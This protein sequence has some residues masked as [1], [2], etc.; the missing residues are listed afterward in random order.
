MKRVA[1]AVAHAAAAAALCVLA[2]AP[3]SAS[4]NV[5]AGALACRGGTAVGMVV[6]SLHRLSCVFRPASGAPPQH[7]EATIRK[8]GLDL[9]I[10]N[11]EVLGW[12]VFAPTRVV[13]PGALAGG[14]GGV[15]AGAAIGVGIGANGLIGGLNNS[16]AL[17]PVSVGA[18]RGI[19]VAGGLAGLELNYVAEPLPR[20]GHSHHRRH[21]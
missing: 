5:S 15:Q 14:Y 9:G 20:R 18:Q 2:L 16:F 19:S 11:G 7:Y 12:L 21:H 4:A 6:T 1:H 8:I 17:Q 10:T 13:G 3:T